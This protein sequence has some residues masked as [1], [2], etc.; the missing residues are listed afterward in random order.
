M[1]TFDEM[2][3]LAR[4]PGEGFALDGDFIESLVEAHTVD[5]QGVAGQS[6]ILTNDLLS[7][8]EAI[9]QL[10]SEVSELKSRNYDLLTRLPA[11]GSNDDA[12]GD[13]GGDEPEDDGPDIDD[14][15]D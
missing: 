7:K 5:M 14:F 8:D 1:A 11:E 6:E 15:F 2:V 10:T 9:A 4:N 13:S 3:E 12:G